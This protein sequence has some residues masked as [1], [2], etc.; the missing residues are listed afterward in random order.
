MCTLEY[1]KSSGV[2]QL[3][4]EGIKSDAG[5]MS[6]F[7]LSG[8]ASLGTTGLPPDLR[9]KVRSAILRRTNLKTGYVLT[10][11]FQNGN[12]DGRIFMNAYILDALDKNYYD[13]NPPAT[14]TITTSD[15]SS[16]KP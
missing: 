13:S 11:L 7:P 5:S 10:D 14:M 12:I 1:A 3:Y 16:D 4:M 6:D 8:N 15:H 9:T 2:E